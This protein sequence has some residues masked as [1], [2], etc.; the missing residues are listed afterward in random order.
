[1]VE[2]YRAWDTR[3]GSEV[4]GVPHFDSGREALGVSL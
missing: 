3:L 2:V 1:M 4:K